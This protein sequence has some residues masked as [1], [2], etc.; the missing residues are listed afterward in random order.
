MKIFISWIQNI[1]YNTCVRYLSRFWFL[2]FC[3]AFRDGHLQHFSATKNLISGPLNLSVIRNG[4]N[5]SE[6]LSWSGS[7]SGFV[8]SGGISINSGIPSQKIA[9][10]FPFTSCLILSPAA[11][12]CIKSFCWKTILSHIKRCPSN[13]RF[14]RSLRNGLARQK[15][16][17]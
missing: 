17:P 14:D 12:L 11:S 15:S 16:G 6:N 5:I 2:V 1:P 9:N 7:K 8:K 13:P 3:H 10:T 4:I